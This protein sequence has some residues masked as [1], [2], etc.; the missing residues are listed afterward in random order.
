MCTENVRDGA[1]GGGG[2]PYVLAGAKQ[3]EDKPKT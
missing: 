3:A 2:E 1:G